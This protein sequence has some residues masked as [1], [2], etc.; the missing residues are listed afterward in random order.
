MKLK[1]S[2]GILTLSSI[3]LM[4]GCA[5]LNELNKDSK[6][7]IHTDKI[8]PLSRNQIEPSEKGLVFDKIKH[9]NAALNDEKRNSDAAHK[10]I[11]ELP[12][13]NDASTYVIRDEAVE[14]KIAKQKTINPDPNV[15]LVGLPTGLP[16]QNYQPAKVD[17]KEMKPVID[18]KFQNVILTTPEE[19]SKTVISKTHTV[20]KTYVV[21]K[22]DTLY[23]IGRKNNISVAEIAK[24]NKIKSNTEVKVGQKLVLTSTVKVLSKNTNKKQTVS[25]VKANQ[26]SSK[27]VTKNN[28]K[29]KK[30]SQKNKKSN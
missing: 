16:G 19:D 30:S 23:S 18:S 24:L 28:P 14:S 17:L 26:K 3:F 5:N 13:L 4:S 10:V 11:G 2:L 27:K 21:K 12:N 6:G 9:T 8:P 7:T 29:D 15:Q 20:N 25:G 22:G 1:F